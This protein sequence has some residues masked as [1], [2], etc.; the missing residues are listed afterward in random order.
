MNEKE[1]VTTQQGYLQP[2]DNFMKDFMDSMVGLTPSFDK[3]KIPSGGGIAFEVPG[4]D[5]ENPDLVKE[6]KGVVLFQYPMNT[7]YRVKYDGSSNPPD[8]SSQDG[9]YGVDA[10]TGEV[11]ECANCPN[12]QFGSEGTHS[13]ACK[14][15]R[16]MYILREGEVFPVVMTIP[17]GSIENYAT[18][19]VRLGNKHRSMSD[20]VTKFSLIKDKNTNGIFYS[21]V[22]M[23]FDRALSQ[24][25]IASLRGRANQLKKMLDKSPMLSDDID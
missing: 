7:Y 1:L 10:E 23:S 11:K 21:K 3:I 22:N 12:F 16:R 2:N 14:Q 13:K 17:T 24:E 19:N 25:E 9:I 8:C 20:V 6:F 18:Y 15:K 5:I 4:D